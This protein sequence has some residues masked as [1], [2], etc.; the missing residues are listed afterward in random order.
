MELCCLGE[1]DHQVSRSL[2]V[3]LWAH[4]HRRGCRSTLLPL[5]H[6]LYFA[7]SG[8]IA[9]LSGGMQ[10]GAEDVVS[11]C[12]TELLHLLVLV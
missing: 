2:L 10:S 4:P 8:A 12:P 7:D 9:A 5:R 3:R 6:L 1:F 11:G